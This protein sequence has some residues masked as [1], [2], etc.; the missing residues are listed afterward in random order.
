M[1]IDEMR[2]MPDEKFPRNMIVPAATILLSLGV[3]LGTIEI[4]QHT[5]EDKINIRYENIN[6]DETYTFDPNVNYDGLDIKPVGTVSK[7]GINGIKVLTFKIND[8]TQTRLVT[9]IHTLEKSEI[10]DIETGAT[11]VDKRYG[12]YY[13]G[14]DVEIIN[15]INMKEY[16][17]A[18][19]K[20]DYEYDVNELI[21]I[22]N[23]G[24]L[25]MYEEGNQLIK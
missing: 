15:E 4:M 3:T 21:D 24:I 13:A 5:V 17:E 14:E 6:T 1:M 10:K 19:K 9:H 7:Y 12:K 20:Y 16:L 2:I 25:P 8:S 18:I 11:I 22:F 23:T